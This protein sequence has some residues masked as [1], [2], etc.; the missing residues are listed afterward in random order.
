M[1]NKKL[2]LIIVILIS[3]LGLYIAFLDINW[4]DF[5]SELRSIDLVWYIGGMAAM[6]MIIFIRALRWRILLLP[7]GNYST[8]KLYKGTIAGFFTNYILPFR[9]GEIA[10]AY[11]T[12]KFIEEKGSVLIPS[13]VIERLIDGVSFFIFVVI[14]SFFIELP[15]SDQQ[16]S[17]IRILLFV[18]LFVLVLGIYLYYKFSEKI[19]GFLDKKEGKVVNF[20]KDLHHGMLF[21]FKVRHPFH[22]IFYSFLIWFVTGLTYWAGLKAMH[23]ELGLIESFILFAAAMVAIAIPA[24]PGFVGT[25]HAAMV[26]ALM[27]FNIDKSTAASYA[28]LQ[29][30]IGMIPLCLFGFIHFLEAN[31]SFKEIKS[32]SRETKQ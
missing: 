7:M 2:Q 31:M 17:L 19:T 5:I 26:G 24:A 28:F 6:L 23:I 16:I 22:I 11:I 13:I 29:H 15:L 12:G 27:A 20:I 3:A 25:F 8:V 1:K 18:I 4:N 21:L 30:L 14:F 10:R 32:V 9:I